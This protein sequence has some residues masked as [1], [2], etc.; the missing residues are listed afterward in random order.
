MATPFV[1]PQNAQPPLDPRTGSF[2]RP[3]YLFFQAVFERIGSATGTG[4]TVLDAMI[5]D[6]QVQLATSPD[7]TAELADLRSDFN[8]FVSAQALIDAAQ[9]A[10]TV[11][12]TSRVA[13]LEVLD[14]FT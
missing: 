7:P 6:L 1:I 3:W 10:A 14:V 13:D 5:S 12:L 9:T 2:N 8:A 11:A 4:N